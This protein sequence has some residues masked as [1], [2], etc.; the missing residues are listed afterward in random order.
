[1]KFLSGHPQ[2]RNA[3]ARW[4]GTKHVIVA[5]HFFWNSGTEM[6]RSQLGLF[7]TLLFHILRSDPDVLDRLFPGGRPNEPWDV[8]ELLSTFNRLSEISSL[9]T[10]FCFF[11]D[12]LDEYDGEEDKIIHAV[13]RLAA[14]PNVK[15]CTSSRPWPSFYA[16]WKSSIYSFAVQDFTR[17][18]MMKYVTDTFSQQPRFASLCMSDARYKRLVRAITERA[19][20]IWLWVHLVVRD[21]LRDIRDNEP[22]ERLKAR[23]E[24]Y[25]RELNKFF[26]RIML[27]ID[28]AYRTETAQIFLLALKAAIPMSILVLP[29]LEKENGYQ[30][31]ARQDLK[32]VTQTQLTTMYHLWHPRLQNRCGDLMKLTKDDS[33]ATWQ[34]YQV[35]FL[36]RTVRDFLHDHYVATLRQMAPTN[37]CERVVLCKL[38]LLGIA[39][40]QRYNNSWQVENRHDSQTKEWISEFLLHLR[41][42][43]RNSDPKVAGFLEDLDAA[44]GPSK[45]T[46][47]ISNMYNL[48]RDAD[49]LSIT[50]AASISQFTASAVMADP[51]LLHQTHNPLLLYALNPTLVPIGHPL[52]PN[53]V[54]KSHLIIHVELVEAFLSLGADPNKGLQVEGSATLKSPWAV[55]LRSCVHNWEVWDSESRNTAVRVVEIL[56]VR[57]AAT[58][59]EWRGQMISVFKLLGRCLEASAIDRL[60]SQSTYERLGIFSTLFGSLYTKG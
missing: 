14:S 47:W 13:T 33:N 44:K 26:E 46:H 30:S 23:L 22:Y 1:M 53:N 59:I 55:F 43:D 38:L 60:K 10:K 36:H 5:S 41:E 49:I 27:H 40:M 29:L 25:P 39:P 34:T 19:Q 9:T 12:G 56:L 28:P 11:I 48:H 2:S 20:G 50:T 32:S 7:H 37:F 15:I 4:A 31:S 35:N 57:G 18:D 24:G 16:E 51:S 8:E 3:L 45:L 52:V 21:M 58:R 42:L 54:L 6:Q 17:N